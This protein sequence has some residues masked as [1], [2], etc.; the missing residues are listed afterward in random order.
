MAGQTQ[1][2]GLA[3]PTGD[4]LTIGSRDARTGL[5]YGVV[6]PQFH[7]PRSLNGSYPYDDVDEFADMDDVYISDDA[8]AAVSQKSLDYNP[9]DHF[10]DNGTDPFYFAGGNTKLS[11]CFWRLDSVLLEIAAFGDSMAAVPQL[12]KQKGASTSGYSAAAPFP[13]G[14]GTSYRRTG[15]LRGYSK[16]PP[17]SKVEAEIESCELDD[18]GDIYTLEDMAKKMLEF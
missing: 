1:R 6:D 15:S 12:T 5:G 16:A 7:L 13:G 8:L 9:V 4:H 3:S 11:D 17:P 10:A 14:G 2:Q 18:E